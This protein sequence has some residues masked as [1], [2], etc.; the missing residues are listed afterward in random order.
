MLMHWKGAVITPDGD[1]SGS[2]TEHVPIP[3]LDHDHTSNYVFICLQT[4][5]MQRIRYDPP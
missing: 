2:Q 1:S 4:R 3:W 5:K